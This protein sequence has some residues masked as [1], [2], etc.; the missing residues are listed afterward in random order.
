MLTL[1]Q[2]KKACSQTGCGCIDNAGIEL[3]EYEKGHVKLKMP[4]NSVN[5]QPMG[6]AYAG[7]IFVL[8]EVGSGNLVTSILDMTKYAPVVQNVSVN[9]Y[10]PCTKDMIFEAAIE[11][12]ELSGILQNIEAKGRG[13]I[14]VHGIVTDEE[15]I[16]Y[17]EAD[18]T[19]YALSLAAFAKK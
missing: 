6:I 14:P 2:A 7:S 3:L 1:E 17:A 9:Y 11:E 16:K 5:K 4:L 18:V 8:C 12:A 10:T 15:G 19:M 13:K